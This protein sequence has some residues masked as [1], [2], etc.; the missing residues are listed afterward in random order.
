MVA[1]NLENDVKS[2]QTGI[3]FGFVEYY[4]SIPLV[5]DLVGY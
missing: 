5:N 3:R 4:I 2:K 1:P